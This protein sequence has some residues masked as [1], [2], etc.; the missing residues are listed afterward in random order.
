MN[1]NILTFII[2]GLLYDTVINIWKPFGTKFLQRI[3]GDSFYI[4]LYN[5]LPGL[6]AAISLFPASML[7]SRLKKKKKITA[8]F[9]FV[10]RF[11]LFITAFVPFLPASIRPLA[12]VLLISIMNCPDAV[13]QNSLQGLLGEMF[14]GRVRAQAISLRVKFGNVIVPMV[15]LITGF[16]IS[17]LPAN[18]QQRI[19]FYQIFFVAA[20]LI[21]LVEIFFFNRFK[22][23]NTEDTAVTADPPKIGLSTVKGILTDK[24][25]TPYFYTTILFLF[26]WQA[27]WP[28]CSIYQIQNL[29]ATEIWLALF[30]V[31]SCISAFLSAGFWRKFIYKHG[32]A[33]TLSLSA[34]LIAGNLLLFPL[35]P[36]VYFMVMLSFYSG[37]ALFGINTC[38]LN[39]LLEVTPDENRL[40][41]IS[42]YNTCANL[43]LFISP[44][45]AHVLLSQYGIKPALFIITGGRFLS[46]AVVYWN[47]RR[48]STA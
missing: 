23:Q 35:T 48:S 7:I 9:I 24:Q 41:Y 16:I 1:P 39:G 25:F 31:S 26:F 44:L 21:G 13:S 45:V 46:S 43:S 19:L 17:Y 20:F 36:N 12:F 6:V 37:F 30:T 29:Q 4:S 15:T 22:V 28:L 8:V 11:I 10:S 34:V 38:I 32:N 42:V 33:K 40:V 14:D 47:A 3:G 18:D 5:S 2:Y 27:G